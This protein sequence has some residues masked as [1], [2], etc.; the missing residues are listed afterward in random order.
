MVNSRFHSVLGVADALNAGIA[1]AWAA[2]KCGKHGWRPSSG[3]ATAGFRCFLDGLIRLRPRTVG[4]SCPRRKCQCENRASMR[5]CRTCGCCHEGIQNVWANH[6]SATIRDRPLPPTDPRC[7]IRWAPSLVQ[8]KVFRS[9]GPS[10][11]ARPGLSVVCWNR[12]SE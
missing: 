11:S 4:C 6:K 8:V 9:V 7:C 10:P 5:G 3:C 12:S 1:K 2:C